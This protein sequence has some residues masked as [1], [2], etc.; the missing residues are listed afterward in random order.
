MRQWDPKLELQYNKTRI[1]IGKDGVPDVFVVL[2]LKPQFLRVEA[3]V[4][5]AEETDSK[6]EEAGLD[7]MPYKAGKYHIRLTVSTWQNIRR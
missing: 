2:R 5:K 6:L 4:P 1:R 3:G 7:V